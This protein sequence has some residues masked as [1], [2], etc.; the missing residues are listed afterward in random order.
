M[1]GRC[2]ISKTPRIGIALRFVSGQPACV[3]RGRLIG[4]R[5]VRAGVGSRAHFV[6]GGRGMSQRHR[7]VGGSS[8]A[9]RLSPPRFL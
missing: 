8:V 6:F 5:N 4:F 9:R 1:P 3:V 7:F 2:Q